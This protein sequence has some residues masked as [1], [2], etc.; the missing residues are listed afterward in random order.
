M[1]AVEDKIGKYDLFLPSISIH[2]L[3]NLSHSLVHLS[4]ISGH[5]RTDHLL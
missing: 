4:A 3:F 5:V 2:T 1:R